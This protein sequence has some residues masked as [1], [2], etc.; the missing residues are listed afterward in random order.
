VSGKVLLRALLPPVRPWRVR[1][2]G[3]REEAALRQENALGL[4]VVVVDCTDQPR[5]NKDG[6]VLLTMTA[7]VTTRDQCG[8]LQR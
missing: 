1:A 6:R 4:L 2:G 3:G 8:L 7:S 5:V